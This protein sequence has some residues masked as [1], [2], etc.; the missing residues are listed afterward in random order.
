MHDFEYYKNLDFSDA[1]PA[2]LNTRIAQ[3]QE[4]KC[5]AM[6]NVLDD[7]VMIWIATQDDT[8][9]RHINDVIRLFMAIKTA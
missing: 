3:M 9:K 7:D 8:T 4:N 6:A 1:K 2:R 5:K